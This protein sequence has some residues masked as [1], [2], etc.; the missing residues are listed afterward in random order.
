MQGAGPA[1]SGGLQEGR[2]G[3]ALPSDMPLGSRT[4]RG[5]DAQH[6]NLVVCRSAGGSERHTRL[7]E[8][9]LPYSLVHTVVHSGHPRYGCLWMTELVIEVLRKAGVRRMITH[10][11]AP[12]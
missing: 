10:C 5:G 6:G 11:F 1:Q 2:G 4:R 3:P 12:S 7:W 9:F 8:N